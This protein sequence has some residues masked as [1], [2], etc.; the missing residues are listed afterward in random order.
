MLPLFL[1]V[2][3]IPNVW[4]SVT[5]P[6]DPA[7]RLINVVAPAA[8]WLLLMTLS[9]KF[10][11]TI[12]LFFPVIFLDAFQIVLLCL[13][14][15]SVIAVDMFLNLFTTNSSEVFELLS[16][17]WLSI[18]LVVL[19][20]I[21]ALV[22]GVVMMRRRIRLQ[23]PALMKWRRG[24]AIAFAGAAVLTCIA[25]VADP[26]WS[27]RRDLFPANAVYNCGLALRHNYRLAHRAELSA[28]FRWDARA[29]GDASTPQIVVLVIGET[30]R[31]DHWSL[32]GYDRPTTPLLDRL[33]AGRL[34]SF[35]RTLS[36]SNTTHKSVPLMLSHLTPDNYGDSIY[37]VKSVIS[38]FSEAGYS[39]AFFS[40][41][42]HNGSFID[43][44]GAE[45][46]TCLFVRD[47]DP[48]TLTNV[49]YDL[50]LL[51]NFDAIM[52]RRAPRQLIVLHAYGSHF[53]YR[54]RY[55]ASMRRFAPDDYS[56]IDESQIDKIVN[57]YDN[58][59][60]VTDSLL[61]AIARRLEA[62]GVNA[63]MIYTSDHGEDIL[64]DGHSFLHASPCP[65]FY[66][67][68]VPMIVWLS[69]SYAA[70]HPDVAAALER[71]RRLPVG[72]NSVFTPTALTLGGITT[73]RVGPRR[74]V[75]S[76][77]YR[78]SPR[79]YLTDHNTGIPLGQSGLRASDLDAL[80][81]LDAAPRK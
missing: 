55:P 59:I 51:D 6:M 66:Q 12:W 41:Q 80:R 44:F 74:S 17:M 53:S 2:L 42:R 49:S 61:S 47:N 27:L 16:N 28:P 77:A 57:S 29:A 36:E 60:L 52:S 9:T 46:D 56:E 67:L 33:D 81:R 65:S 45:A 3:I 54:D 4:L 15:R 79:R 31:G 40:N 18:L 8:A 48:T 62:T 25:G 75:A 21:P 1:A 32:N 39:T 7:G 22:V 70:A 11:R 68:R 30:A 5:E 43:F 73:P 38:A 64:E 71:N 50:R 26:G 69:G 34:Y 58:S 63:A 19:L 76:A 24:A 78:P 23:R 13:F 10:G 37:V 72:T 14:G 35:S 20:Y